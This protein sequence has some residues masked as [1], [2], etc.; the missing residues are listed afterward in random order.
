MTLANGH[1]CFH[2]PFFCQL[3][4]MLVFFL[5]RSY[6]CADVGHLELKTVLRYPDSPPDATKYQFYK[7]FF[8]FATDAE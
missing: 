1:N 8:F 4:L 6:L 2:W 3:M 7:T 5:F